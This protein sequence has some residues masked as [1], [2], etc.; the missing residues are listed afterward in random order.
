M[1]QCVSG[2]GQD[3]VFDGLVIRN[4]FAPL[5]D[6]F[7]DGNPSEYRLGGGV[8]IQNSSPA[9]A[10][11]IFEDNQADGTG[12][13][14]GLFAGSVNDGIC[15]PVFTNCLFTINRSTYDGGGA[16]NYRNGASFTNCT[17]E[18]NAARYAG[19]SFNQES[20]NNTYIDCAFINNSATSS[21]GGM[22]QRDAATTLNNC[23]F[24]GNSAGSG[25]GVYNSSSSISPILTD[26]TVCGNV[27][28]QINGNYTDNGGNCISEVCDSDEDGTP[29]CL[30]GCPDDPDETEPGPCGCA[31]SET[32]TDGDGIPDCIDPCPTWPYECSQDGQTLVVTTALGPGA[33]QLAIEQVPTGG[34]VTLAAGTYLMDATIDPM[35]KALTLQGAID[36]DTGI[37]TSILDGQGL[38][39]VL[40]CVSGEGPDTVFEDLVIRGGYAIGGF[41]NNIGGGM[42]IDGSSPTLTHCTFTQNSA[43]YAGGMGVYS[44]SS[45]IL[46]NLSFTANSAEVNG[47]A[48]LISES[49]ITLTDCS[50]TDN[51]ADEWGGGLLNYV[52][53]PLLINCN[54]TNNSTDYGGGIYNYFS[55]STLTNC[56][57]TDNSAGNGGGLYNYN[58]G[59]SVF[60]LT[61]TTVCGNVPDQIDGD[62]NDN[63]GNCIS[64]VCDSDDD[65]TPDCLDCCP[66]DPDKTEPGICGCAG[67]E[68]DT[69]GDGIADCIDP[70]PTWPYDCSEDGQTITIQIGDGR[71]INEAI[72]AAPEG[73]TVL[74]GPGTWNEAIDF[75]GQAVTVEAESSLAAEITILDGTGLDGPIISFV[76]GEG[77]DSVLRG[78]T[79]RNGTSG[80]SALNEA[81]TVGGAIFIYEASPVIEDCLFTDNNADYGGAVYTLRSAAEIQE[82]IFTQN[83]S[84][85]HGGGLQFANSSALASGC[86]FTHNVSGE[87]GGGIHAFGGSSTI[88]ECVFT[89]N[90]SGTSGGAI[91]WGGFGGT[92]LIEDSLIVDNACFN[93]V[94]GGLFNNPD[95]EADGSD[96]VTLVSTSLCN[97]SPDQI[98]GASVIDGGDTQICGCEGDITFDGDVNGQDL[99][100][101]LAMWGA[102]TSDDPLGCLADFNGDGYVNG[103]DLTI[104]LSNWG[105]CE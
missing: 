1:L 4:G 62:Y 103:A 50:F 105:V 9:L 86:T 77:P 96:T 26:T 47:G 101:V 22:S 13:G 68:F 11:C 70:C 73:G 36:P 94:G 55:S 2:E 79:L 30:D 5:T 53:S 7:S 15:E 85:I 51:S 32:D 8:L 64:Q 66:D 35:G 43:S 81:F 37:P 38:Y 34:M 52:C 41:P 25:G 75:G 71:S 23:S 16:F 76:N 61:D 87:L 14:G 74:V 33:I 24:T 29:D 17:F 20:D 63:G 80:S 72:A 82:C 6:Y 46:S 67:S 92:L 10:N 84:N 99:G 21:G 102:C 12:F 40:Q 95:P 28:D 45:P 104:I 18:N 56:T 3:T 69:D 31:G 78:F 39:R 100:T 42:Y 65:G 91:S 57:V 60:T 89:D 19:G 90:L 83:S 49:S 59:E 88:S 44:N 54:F 97:N 58:P 98:A 27:P 48:M 93:G